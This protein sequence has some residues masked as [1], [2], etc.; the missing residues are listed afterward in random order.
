M[1]NRLKVYRELT[2]MTQGEFASFLGVH[3]VTYNRWERQREQPNTEKLY[4]IWLRLKT[5][6]DLNMQDLLGDE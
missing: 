6:M 2:G 3:R 1:R 4:D 5:K